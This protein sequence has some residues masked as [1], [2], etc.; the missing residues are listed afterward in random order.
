LGKRRKSKKMNHLYVYLPSNSNISNKT[1]EFTTILNENLIL[2]QN[3]QVAL[4]E[5]I[6]KHSWNVSIGYISYSNDKNK[7]YKSNI[8][9][10]HDSETIASLINRINSTIKSVILIKIYN[11]RY[12]E[13][14]LE[15]Q[16]ADEFHAKNQIYT[17]KSDKLYPIFLYEE[18]IENSIVEEIK[19]EIEYLKC[20]ELYIENNLLKLKFD[21]NFEGSLQFVGSVVKILEIEENNFK[22]KIFTNLKT[23]STLVL[24]NYVNQ[25]S[26]VDIVGQLYIYAP[27]LVEYQFIGNEKAPLLAIVVVEPNTFN[28]VIKLTLHPPHYL[29]VI[30]NSIKTIRISIRDQF[31]NKILF[32][33]STITLKLD[34]IKNG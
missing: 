19:N 26:P 18:H 11:Q 5:V 29:N 12:D 34:F 22:S 20:P 16:K 27:D 21:K 10:F 3:C 28:K 7:F 31:G 2:P 32:D 15:Q 9:S 25:L 8:E 23:T 30:Q 24:N 6:Y 17:F 13:R 1:T 33:D 4:V 14:M